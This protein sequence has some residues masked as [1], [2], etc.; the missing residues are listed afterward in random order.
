M[1]L[2]IVLQVPPDAVPKGLS[3]INC[4]KV[5]KAERVSS[6]RSSYS[7]R[8]SQPFP[9]SRALCAQLFVFFC[10]PRTLGMILTCPGL[11][12]LPAQYVQCLA[13]SGTSQILNIIPCSP[14]SLALPFFAKER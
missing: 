3:A 7:L 1:L 8:L 6:F 12:V 11:A 13:L 9:L 2:L 10:F 4:G 14:V 5:N